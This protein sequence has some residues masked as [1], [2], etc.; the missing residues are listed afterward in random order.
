MAP[1]HLF[2]ATV[3]V[4][5]GVAFSVMLISVALVSAAVMALG[6]RGALAGAPQ[7]HPPSDSRPD[8]KPVGYR[9][10]KTGA[11][12]PADGASDDSLARKG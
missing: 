9:N 4:G 10:L 11:F 5:A 8:G 7:E 12:V 6:V 1:W 2:L 3:A